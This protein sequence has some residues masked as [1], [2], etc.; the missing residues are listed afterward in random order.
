MNYYIKIDGEPE[1]VTKIRHHI[2]DEF[3][4]LIFYEEEH[5]YTLFGKELPSV[6]SITHKFQDEFDSEAQAE[7]Y[8]AKHGETKE[9]WLDLWGYNA[10]RATTLGTRVHAYGESLGW[11]K[12]GHPEL[13]VPEILPQYRKDKNWL[14]P[15][16]KKEEAIEKFMNDLPS[17]YHLVLNET[18][19]YSGKNKDPKLNPLTQYSGT[20]DMLYYYDGEGNPDKAGLVIFDY[21]TNKDLRSDFARSKNKKMYPPFDDLYVE[22]LGNYSLQLSCY[23]IPL[24]DIGYKVIDRKLIWLKDDGT[25]EKVHTPNLTDKLRRCI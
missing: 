6:S 15:I 2:L 4:D 24:E 25:Y 12:G 10:F 9:Y 20:F 16:H 8:A 23:Q 21:K 14:V 1:I 18:K 5:K 19:I 13:I 17:S 7:A 11:F 22:S 3:K